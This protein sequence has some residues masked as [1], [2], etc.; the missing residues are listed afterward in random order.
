MKAKI[1]AIRDGE[2]EKD[3]TITC[4]GSPFTCTA[5]VASGERV[6]DTDFERNRV[7]FDGVEGAHVGDG[8]FEAP[9]TLKPGAQT[10]PI[11]AETVVK[12]AQPIVSCSGCSTQYEDRS[13]LSS[14]SN[15]TVHG[16]D[17]KV[18]PEVMLMV[19]ADGFLRDDAG[20][21]FTSSGYTPLTHTVV[22]MKG[23]EA[24]A[25]LPVVRDAATDI[26]TIARG[27]RFDPDAD[28]TMQAVMNAGTGIEIR[29]DPF[30]VILCRMGDI[31][32]RGRERADRRGAA[33]PERHGAGP[34][35]RSAPD[36]VL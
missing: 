34:S 17:Y 20:F 14:V 2:A 26:I 24:V 28:Y 27:F 36:V 25:Y 13:F 23:D 10:I 31:F 8:I 22:L 19:D 5:V 30:P 32:H 35:R 11:V 15:M 16:V 9:Y 1:Y 33:R 12:T 3:R 7:T 21:R 29:S 6:V 18:P 4:G